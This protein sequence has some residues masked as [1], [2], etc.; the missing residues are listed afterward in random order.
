M[1]RNPQRSP[2]ARTH[3]WVGASL[4]LA[5][6]AIA[7]QSPAQAA[8]APFAQFT[9]AQNGTPFQF[10]NNTTNGTLGITSVTTPV[11]FNF[12]S[13]P[14]TS[15]HA[16]T[17]SLT[18]V[19]N[20]PATSTPIA[21]SNF[22]DQAVNGA[23]NPNSDVLT[24]TDNATGK[25]LLSMVF[26]GD[27]AGFQNDSTGQLSGNTARGNTVTFSSDFGT[28]AA[29]A[30]SYALGLTSIN[31]VLSIGP[32]GFLNSFV[33]SL[34]GSFRSSFQPAGAVPEPAS[35]AMFGTGLF[36]TAVLASQRKRLAM[37]RESS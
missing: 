6:L 32:G 21:G 27:I 33:S 37:L 35:V 13:G 25:I 16:A 12:V 31:P 9:Q 10:S 22:L 15:S 28:F 20:A 7:A 24:I 30:N 8:P 2:S 17:L 34:S 18:A 29:G 5:A 14:D 3:R 4:A 1:E 19:T 26:T 23:G 36:A 11:N